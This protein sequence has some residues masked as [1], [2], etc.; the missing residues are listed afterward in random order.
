MPK[1]KKKRVEIERVQYGL[2]DIFHDLK[3]QHNSNFF[4]VYVATYDYF[5]AHKLVHIQYGSEWCGRAIDIHTAT[6][7]L[8]PCTCIP[9]HHNRPP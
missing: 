2:D 9:S 6:L 5:T 4:S 1:R 3:E 8:L 7:L